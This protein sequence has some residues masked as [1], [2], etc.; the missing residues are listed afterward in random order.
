MVPSADTVIHPWAV[1]V[2]PQDT[3]LAHAAVMAARWL[4]AP[5]FM[6]LFV[7]LFHKIRLGLVCRWPFRI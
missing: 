3:C 1:M 5:A 4:F 7:V 2:H 6:A